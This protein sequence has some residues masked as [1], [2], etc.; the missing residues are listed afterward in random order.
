M[1]KENHVYISIDL[2]SFYASVEC[3]ERGLDPLTTN[4]VVADV[5]RTEK[6]IC[7]AV[8]PSL[9]AYGISGRARLFEVVRKVKEVNA[10]RL[11]KAPG[12][13]FTGSSFD[14]RELKSHPELSISYVAAVPRM[15]LYME[16]STKI[17][18][19]Y[20][21]YIAP[22]D[23]HVYSIDEVFMDVTY[24][25][26]T[27]GLSPKELAKKIIQEILQKTG[28]TATAG[29]GANL[30]LSKVAMDI[31][32]KKVAPDED[33]V[34]IAILDETDY[35]RFLWS[36]RPLTD[37]WRVGRGYA[38]KLEENGLFTM[39]DIARCSMGKDTDYYNEE[40]LYRLFGINAELL[41]D[42]A[43]GWEPC[44]I[45]D[46]KAYKPDKSSMGSGQVLQCPYSFEKARLIV[47]EMTD[48]LALDL[49][50][51]GLTTD[52]MV[53]TIGYDRENLSDPEI[54]NRYKG[55]VTTDQYGR[56]VP[57][58]AHG[59]INL[60]KATSS[61]RLILDAVTR[62]YDQIVH[63]ELSIRRVYV[64]ANHVIE[65]S[66]AAEE[67]AF[68]QLDLFTD[69]E[70]RQR[71]NEEEKAELEREKKIQKAMLDIKK[72]FGKNAVLKGMNLEEGAMSVE[73]NR[74]IG[75]HKA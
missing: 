36:H 38:R 58:H 34:R 19:I 40:L 1:A 39:G 63:K 75:G 62:L 68:E 44:T 27:Y 52:Q 60:G 54:R 41:I 23:I 2:K 59:T 70:A 7:L 6:T 37:F 71:Q 51:K 42:H 55:P 4:L 17:Y 9:K 14:D 53:L 29:I 43:W 13:F 66:R 65:E 26:D 49:V 31:M 16:Y 28:I 56:K 72:K 30:Y 48:L 74:Q 45:A 3:A 11:S 20:L 24:Y 64:T 50:D 22:E 21:Q 10:L 18:N 47:R 57:K 12:H 33:G 32:A 25:L 73:R 15:A 5:S 46:V 8:S 67:E 61:A 69:Y 35:R